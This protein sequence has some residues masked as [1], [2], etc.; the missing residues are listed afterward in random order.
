MMTG[1]WSRMHGDCQRLN[2]IYKH[3]KRKC[4]KSDADLVENAKTTHME[5][6]GNKK[7]QYIH[8]WNILKNYPKWNAM[9]PIDEDNLT[10]LFGPDPRDRP[11]GKP[12]AEAAYQAKLDKEL[13]MLQWYPMPWLEPSSKTPLDGTSPTS[14]LAF[15]SVEPPPPHQ[16]VPETGHV[17]ARDPHRESRFQVFFSCYEKMPKVGVL[18]GTRNVVLRRE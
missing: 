18:D 5:R 3:L 17:M 9:E 14:H 15:S 8:S 7:I 4:G 12:W 6:C 11:A 1:K 2:A 16:M 10:E 13:G